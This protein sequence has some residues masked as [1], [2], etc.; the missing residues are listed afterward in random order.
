MRFTYRPLVFLSSFALLLYASSATQ[1]DYITGEL[2]SGPID[3]TILN[4]GA[5]VKINFGDGKAP[6]LNYYPGVVNWTVKKGPSGEPNAAWVPAVGKA[7]KTFCIEL[8]QD[9]NPG[10]TYTY[11]L[12]NLKD[13]PKPGTSQSGG[14]GGMGQNKANAIGALWAANYS[15]TVPPPLGSTA[16]SKAAANSNAAAFQ[17]AIWKIE[18]DWGN[19][20]FNFSGNGTNDFNHG[21]FRA[22]AISSDSNSSTAIATADAWLK[23]LGWNVN[24]RRTETGLIA[25]S[26]PSAQDQVMALPHPTVSFGS[27][28][29]V[30]PTFYLAAIGGLALLLCRRRL[31]V[32]RVAPN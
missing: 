10:K 8:T 9:I 31:A 27:P 16:K 14:S 29:P 17:L 2:V 23:N 12:V 7:F 6:S 30:P 4:P 24:G 15:S 25:L 1:A 3:G 32:M 19:S 26:S 5:S 11:N 18:Y 22:S 13:A 28:V 21:N 20:S